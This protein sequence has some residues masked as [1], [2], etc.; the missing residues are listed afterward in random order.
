M[1]VK[2]TDIFVPFKPCVFN[3]S[4]SY[5]YQKELPVSLSIVKADVKM[6]DRKS[7]V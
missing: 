7:V 4:G 1:S 3:G 5:F 2:V 6:T